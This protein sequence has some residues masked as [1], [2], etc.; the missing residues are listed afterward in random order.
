MPRNSITWELRQKAKKL[1]WEKSQEAKKQR[2]LFL[3]NVRHDSNKIRDAAVKIIE[4]EIINFLSTVDDPD[5]KHEFDIWNL[6][7]NPILQKDLKTKIPPRKYFNGF[8]SKELRMHNTSLWKEAGIMLMREEINKVLYPGIQLI[9]ISDQKKSKNIDIQD[10]AKFWDVVYKCVVQVEEK[11]DTEKDKQIQINKVI[12][13]P[14]NA[15]F[16]AKVVK[17][18]QDA[19]FAAKVV[20]MAQDADLAAKVVQTA[21]NADLTAKMAKNVNDVN[22]EN[23]T[24]MKIEKKKKQIKKLE[25]TVVS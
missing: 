10:R 11:F 8:W 6:H 18:A 23:I 14:K 7:M 16:A 17:M 25:I 21:K 24:S 20:Q 3:Q 19:D 15:D 1:K 9:D 22:K 4:N 13:K 12:Q 2:I 5:C